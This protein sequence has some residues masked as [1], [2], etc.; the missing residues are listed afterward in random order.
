RFP[1]IA[2]GVSGF[3]EPTSVTAPNAGSATAEGQNG[4]RVVLG[5]VPNHAPLLAYME[6]VPTDMTDLWDIRPKAGS[7]CHP[8]YT[9]AS[10]RVGAFELWEKLFAGDP[11]VVLSKVGWPVA[12]LFVADFDRGKNFWS[13]YS[14][15]FDA[16]GDNV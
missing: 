9:P 13:G 1:S 7:R 15:K 4:V 16:N 12:P 11:Q 5:N 6:S 3:A 8:A 2:I 10:D 14:G